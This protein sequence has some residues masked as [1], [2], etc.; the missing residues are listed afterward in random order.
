MA[1]LVGRMGETPSFTL[2]G[3][4][5]TKSEAGRKGGKMTAQRYGSTHMEAIGR[6]GHRVT[7]ERYYAGD[8]IA[9][10][11]ALSH[12]ANLSGAVWYEALQC[13]QVL[14]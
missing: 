7:C 10:M 2:I 12:R 8:V 9:M 6:E 3:E 14:A 11:T 13:W 1:E 5:M 4:S